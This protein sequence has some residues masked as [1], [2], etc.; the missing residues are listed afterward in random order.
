MTIRFKGS[1]F[2]VADA[3]RLLKKMKDLASRNITI[4]TRRAYAE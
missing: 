4:Y 1:V 2:F 3:G